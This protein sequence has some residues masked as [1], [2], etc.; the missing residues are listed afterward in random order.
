MFK[1]ALFI[2]FITT[3]LVYGQTSPTAVFYEGSVYTLSVL[4]SDIA[5]DKVNQNLVSFNVRKRG[6]INYVALYTV[7]SSG[8]ASPLYTKENGRNVYLNTSHVL[9]DSKFGEAFSFVV[10]SHVYAYQNGVEKILSVDDFDSI[11]V[12]AFYNNNVYLDNTLD[13][14]IRFVEYNPPRIEVLDVLLSRPNNTYAI[15]LKYSGGRNKNVSF[16]YRDGYDSRVYNLIEPII[17]YNQKNATS[18]VLKDTFNNGIGKEYIIKVYFRAENTDQYLFFNAFDEKGETS[19]PPLQVILESVYIEEPI[20]LA[21]VVEE[22]ESVSN[23]TS[24]RENVVATDNTRTT[25]TSRVPVA[26]NSSASRRSNNSNNREN[27]VLVSTSQESSVDVYEFAQPVYLIDS[28]DNILADDVVTTDY[29]EEPNNKIDTIETP[30]IFT[31]Q[32]LTRQNFIDFPARIISSIAEKSGTS[33][34]LVFVLDVTASMHIALDSVK[35]HVDEIVVQMYSN[36]DTV[37]VGFVLFK[38]FD[39]DF[40]VKSSGYMTDRYEIKRFVY[41]LEASGGGDLPEPILDAID[42]AL[43]DY[44]FEA[45]TRQIFVITDATTK[46]SIYTSEQSIMDRVFARNIDLKYFVLPMMK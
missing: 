21:P 23:A 25:S 42:H 29:T 22:P 34:D 15:T 13:V 5:I 6:D 35:R 18:I 7:D 12:R 30:R 2:F 11:I 26:V 43:V 16:Y 37:R 20:A 36:Y 8:V 24:D 1:S 10:P 39:D 44:S 38:D 31:K 40:F 9:R 4:S 27:P 17:K 46:R 3:F 19:T 32:H 14:D 33:L 28:S 45:E 41:S